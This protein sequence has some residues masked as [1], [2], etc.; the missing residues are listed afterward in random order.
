MKTTNDLKSAIEVI[1]GHIK[2][3][4]D[5]VLKLY[6]VRPY[7]DKEA[8][9]VE[10]LN[11]AIAKEQENI[12]THRQLIAY[13]ES[14]PPRGIEESY[15]ATLAR[16]NAIENEVAQWADKEAKKKVRTLRGYAD[17]KKQFKQL[18][19]LMS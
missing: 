10:K 5:E 8:K 18:Q 15:N 3:L 6:A 4:N 12:A 17:V 11:S 1:K 7:T 19:Y 14:T 9:A 16:L 2:R 13:I